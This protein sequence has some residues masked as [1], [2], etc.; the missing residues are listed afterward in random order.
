MIR[1]QA[2]EEIYDGHFYDPDDMVPVGC[3]DCQ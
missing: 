3:S 2:I 1:G